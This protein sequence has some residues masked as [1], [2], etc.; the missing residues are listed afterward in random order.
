MT[1][2]NVVNYEAQIALSGNK[3]MKIILK[4]HQEKFKRKAR[5]V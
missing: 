2:I 5:K 4:K 3:K 1:E